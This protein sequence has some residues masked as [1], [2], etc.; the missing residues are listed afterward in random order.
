MHSLRK[1][2]SLNPAAEAGLMNACFGTSETRALT[3]LA[4]LR[5]FFGTAAENIHAPA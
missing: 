5:I 1:R 2:S 3:R 4:I